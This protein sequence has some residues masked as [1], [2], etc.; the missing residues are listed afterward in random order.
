M[1]RLT[2]IFFTLLLVA[3]ATPQASADTQVPPT[4]TVPVTATPVLLPSLTAL[5]AA[6]TNTPTVTINPTVTNVPATEITPKPESSLSILQLNMLDADNGWAI[7]LGEDSLRWYILR[8]TDGGLSWHDVTSPQLITLAEGKNWFYGSLAALDTNTAWIIMDD[9]TTDEGMLFGTVWQTKD[10]GQ[11]WKPS[12]QITIFN[13]ADPNVYISGYEARLQFADAKHG[14]LR[15]RVHGAMGHY[16]DAW[17]HTSD[18]GVTWEGLSYYDCFDLTLVCEYLF[19]NE[20]TGFRSVEND[21][22]MGS[23]WLSVGEIETDSNWQIEKT[24]DAGHDWIKTELPLLP[25]FKKNLFDGQNYSPSQISN[26]QVTISKH[27]E[28]F[29][30]G[31]VGIRMDFSVFPSKHADQP[32]FVKSYHYLSTNKGLTWHVIPFLG[33]LFFLDDTLGW[34]YFELNGN[35]VIE[36]T[37][38]GGATWQTISDTLPGNGILQFEDT[39]IGWAIIRQ[40][41]QYTDDLITLF[42]TT[43]GGQTWTEIKPVIGNH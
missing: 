38:D 27:I 20:N 30:P 36:K 9:A 10:G 29:A 28:K 14:W 4:L 32:L 40:P 5:P 6:L 42:H 1:R 19:V 35:L 41:S 15:A 11:S 2:F 18:G 37:S 3:C 16:A 12:N 7:V 26:F 13:A 24:T 17:F 34:G 22:G 8:T 31:M 21:Y 33:N 25:D 43:D 23:Q 39:S